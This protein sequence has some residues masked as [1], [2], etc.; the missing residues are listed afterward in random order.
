MSTE[1]TT[2]TDELIEQLLEAGIN[3]I[4]KG[5]PIVPCNR[6]VPCDD[7]GLPADDWQNL[8]ISI[9]RLEAGLRGADD[10]AIGLIMGPR[11]GI[12]DSETDGPDEEEAEAHLFRGCHTPITAAYKSPRGGHTLW[13]YDPR[14]EVL[15]K[16]SYT[17]KAP[18]GKHVTIRLGLGAKASQSIIPPSAG[19]EWLPGVSPD[20]CDIQPL[21]ELVIQ[22]LLAAVAKES[23]R[24]TADTTSNDINSV[25]LRAMQSSTKSI[26]DGNDGSKRLYIVACRAVEYDLSDSEAVATIR[27]YEAEKPFPRSWSDGEV[28]QR[29]RD[30]DADKKVFRGSAVI[31]RNY[32]EIEVEI[33]DDDEDGKKKTKTVLVP[34][35]MTDIIADIYRHRG[36]WPRRVDNSL[37]VDDEHGLS[38]FD[39]RTTPAVFGWM[40]RNHSVDWKK[41]GKYVTQPELTAEIERTATK[42]EAIELFP[43]EPPIHGIYYR[44]TPPKLGDGSHLKWLLDRFRPETTIDYD[45]IKAAFMTAMWGGPAGCRPAFVITSDWGRGVGKSTVAQLIGQLFGGHIDVSAGEDISKLKTR[46]LTPEARTKRIA[47][48]DNIKTMKLSW[49][50]LESLITATTISGH[51]LY[52]GEGQRPNVLTW[53][54]TLNGVSL[55]TDMAQRSVIIKVV[56]GENSGTWLEETRTYIDKHRDKIIGDIIAALRDEP[57]PLAEY[58]RWAT[59]EEHVLTRLPEPGDAQRVILERQG[60]ANCEMDEAEIVEGYF[61]DQ[62]D[63]L[64]YGPDSAQVRIPVAIVARWYCKATNERAKTPQISKHLTQMAREGQLKCLSPD[65]SRSYGRCFVWTGHSA[66][67]LNHPICNDLQ[68]RLNVV[69]ADGEDA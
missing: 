21:P 59:W 47:Q 5:L 61:A 64:G 49:A 19:R 1:V 54:L 6:K 9:E 65:P 52:V 20:E 17:Y 7:R 25:C 53:F 46:F 24:Q 55:A 33:D 3:G 50:E 44:G 43:H 11:S 62:L 63:R 42:Y 22:R 13:K 69:G 66:D 18:N 34:K 4:G 37:F 14:L 56:K 57:F 31:I 10:P 48:I 2:T 38:W 45:L 67:V 51:Q 16:A 35:S 28:L 60:E 12:I 30:A 36:N 26:E 15:G 39:R 8:P 29:V 32:D 23:K 68:S 58:S 40:R 41:G 27:A